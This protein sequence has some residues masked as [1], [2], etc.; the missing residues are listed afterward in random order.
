MLFCTIND[1]IAYGNLSGYNV[2]GHR[3]C[4]IYEEDTRYVQLK[5]GRKIVYTRHRYFLKPYHPYHRLKK[6]FNGSQEHEIAPIPL[7]GQ[8]VLERVED[9]NTIFGETKKKEKSKTSI[10]KNRS[11]L[12]DLPYWSNLDIRHCINVMHVEK[13]VC[14][15]VI[16]T[17]LNIQG[18]TKDSLNTRQDLLE[19]GIRD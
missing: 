16:D 4:P 7:T 3:A 2:K 12:F 13:N 19:M 15:N 8:Q 5:H 9:I 11:I 10:W 1:F 6:A 18:K 14:D 17:L